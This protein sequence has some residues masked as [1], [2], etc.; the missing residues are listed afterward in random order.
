MSG[1]DGVRCPGAPGVCI[2]LALERGPVAALRV[3][4]PEYVL[5]VR[6]PL[7]V[8]LQGCGCTLE[9][10]AFLVRNLTGALPRSRAGVAIER[11]IMRDWLT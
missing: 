7:L 3:P 11:V 6:F 9:D 1:W 8:V 4:F 2:V 10:T 5:G